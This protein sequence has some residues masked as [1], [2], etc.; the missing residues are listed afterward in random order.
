MTLEEKVFIATSEGLHWSTLK[1]KVG[2]LNV[3]EDKKIVRF[4]DSYFKVTL[5][6]NEMCVKLTPVDVQ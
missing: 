3:D 5:N 2:L 4:K 6:S 1:A